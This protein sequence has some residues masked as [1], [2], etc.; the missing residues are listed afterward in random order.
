MTLVQKCGL[1]ATMLL[2]SVPSASAFD[3]ICDVPE[4][5]GPAG[6]SALAVIASLGMVAFDRFKS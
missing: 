3:W 1:A 4:I 5:D 6:L 2:W